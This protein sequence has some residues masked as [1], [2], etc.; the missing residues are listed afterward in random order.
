MY[1]LPSYSIIPNENRIS[2]YAVLFFNVCFIAAENKIISKKSY[3]VFQI[4]SILVILL[5]QSRTG[6]FL[7][8]LSYLFMIYAYRNDF[9]KQIK[10]ISFIALGTL[11]AYIIVLKYL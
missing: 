1:I 4:F 2:R 11:F 5:T 10:L 8:L 6:L 9:L 3:T 7:L